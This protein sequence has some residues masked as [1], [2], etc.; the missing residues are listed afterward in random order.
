MRLLVLGG[1]R[2]VGR[3]VVDEAVRRGYDVTTFTRGVSGEPR[4]GAEAL[5]GDRANADD[6]AKLGGRDW[7]AVID[8]SMLAPVHV[9]S[10]AQVLAG[11]V[12]HYTYVSSLRVYRDWPTVPVDESSPIHDC[13]PD[14]AGDLEYSVLK[15]GCERAV[16][17]FFPGRCLFVRAGVITGPHE[18][19][20]RLPWW[21]ERIAAGGLVVAPG[22]P[23]DPVRF[24]DVRDLA[25]WILDNTRR[26]IPGAVDIPGAD[27]HTFGELLAA[28]EDVMKAGRTAGPGKKTELVWVPHETLLA[29][30]VGPWWELPM[31]TPSTP[32]WAGAWRVDGE[33]A[34]MTGI[35]YRSLADTVHDTWRWL[36][37]E[38]LARGGPV[39]TGNG[40]TPGAR[41]PGGAW[42]VG[43]DPAREREILA[44]LGLPA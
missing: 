43:L 22:S 40:S 4:P 14:A 13:P 39:A 19:P 23:G 10:S 3:A 17:E 29:A 28:C 8:T 11:H 32:Q 31:W 7:D 2:F 5:H 33:R 15:A 16:A 26:H 12:A 30:G 27:G 20:P 25:G 42:Q 24:V 18:L 35:H 37:Q 44:S 36:R 41:G 9:Y 1:T 21:L 38:E 6:L 34:R